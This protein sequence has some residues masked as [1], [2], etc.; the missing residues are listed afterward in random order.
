[1][2]RLSI[3]FNG[4]VIQDLEFDQDEITI[5]RNRDNAVQIDNVTVSGKHARI[6]REKN[7]YLEAKYTY[8]LEDLESTNGT[9]VN[10]KRISLRVLREKDL[11][12]VG[13][14]AI[15]VSF[16]K[17]GM[18]DRGQNISEIEKTQRLEPDRQKQIIKKLFR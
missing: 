8:M 5:G 2:I 14:H 9:F 1:M 17:F 12:T 15:S 3:R 7:K 11:I 10:D 4:T 16:R 18:Q 13:K 6:I